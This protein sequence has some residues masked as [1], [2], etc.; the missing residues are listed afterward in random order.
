LCLVFRLELQVALL[1][2]PMDRELVSCMPSLPCSDL[3]GVVTH[4]CF[5]L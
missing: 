1:R 2:S 5:S 4:G 3:L